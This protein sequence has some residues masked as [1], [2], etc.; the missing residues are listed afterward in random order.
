LAGRLVYYNSYGYH[1]YRRHHPQNYCSCHLSL[2]A[3][4]HRW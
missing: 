4:N 3:P 2:A 1:Q